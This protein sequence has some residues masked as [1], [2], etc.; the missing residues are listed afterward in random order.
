MGNDMLRA[1]PRLRRWTIGIFVT[2]AALCI[3]AALAFQRWMLDVA[4][5]AQSLDALVP[6]LQA[7]TALA[8]TGSAMCLA[9]LAWLAARNGRR[10]CQTEQWPLPGARVIRD[11]PMRRGAPARR[12]GRL[13]QVTALALVAL[14]I[15]AALV[16]LRLFNLSR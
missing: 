14:A 16:S 12:V 11:T 15:G 7:W 5:N 2:A 3:A 13:L 10:A 9:V 6:R 1:D 8:L 4:G